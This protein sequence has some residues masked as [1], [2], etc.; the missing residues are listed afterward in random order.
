MYGSGF[1]KIYTTIASGSMSRGWIYQAITFDESMLY[2]TAYL[3]CLA[4][5]SKADNS[6]TQQVLIGST[7]GTGDVYTGPSYTGI[8]LSVDN[9]AFTVSKTTLYV[10]YKIGVSGP[11]ASDW[12]VV[13]RL[14]I[15]KPNLNTY[16]SD[17]SRTAYSG[18]L[19]PNTNWT[20]D[21]VPSTSWT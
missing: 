11:D 9:Q 2:S 18:Y 17:G 16:L 14:Q 15:Y 4:Y 8:I 13:D 10:T 3:S 21:S 6:I 12:A 20:A 7:H 1:G 19:S 5:C